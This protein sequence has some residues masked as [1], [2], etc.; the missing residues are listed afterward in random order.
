MDK[1]LQFAVGLA[2][3]GPYLV[4][5][6]LTRQDDTRDAK[7]LRQSHALGAGDAHLRRAVHLQVRRNLPGQLGNAHVLHDDGV[8]AGGGNGRQGLGRLFQLMVEDK[9]VEG[10]I[11]AHAAPV[12]RRHHIGQFGQRE[13]DLGAGGEVL[14]AKVDGVGACFDRGMQL[15]PVAGRAHH[16]WFLD[17]VIKLV[18]SCCR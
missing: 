15:R 8:D 16:L 17:F 4:Q 18:T 10:D 13:A 9:R 5:R 1:H 6:Q 12:Q 2:A 14:E 3:N 7:L 11:A